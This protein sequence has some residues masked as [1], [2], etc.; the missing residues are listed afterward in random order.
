[1]CLKV[2]DLE[3]IVTPWVLGENPDGK[4][5]SSKG[6]AFLLWACTITLEWLVEH[7]TFFFWTYFLKMIQVG[8]LHPNLVSLENKSN[9]YT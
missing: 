3:D 2:R 5:R 4:A 9:Q 7:T 6:E 1:M 8:Q